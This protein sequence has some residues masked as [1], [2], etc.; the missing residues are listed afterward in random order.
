MSK[1][2]FSRRALMAAAAFG[3]TFGVLA[4][5]ASAEM[6]KVRFTMDWAW[7]GP[8]ATALLAKKLGYFEAEGVDI[9][10]NR[11]FGSGRVPV[12]L[13]AG[14]YDMGQGDMS[15]VI[16]FKA[17]NPDSQVMTVA[18]LYDGSPLVAVVKADGPI[19]SPKDFEGKTLAAPDFDAGRQLFPVFA[20]ATGIDM[21]KVNWMSVKPELREPM[22]AQGQADGITGFITS[23]KF[24][25]RALGME[26]GRD[27]T[28]FRYVDYGVDLYSTGIHTTRGFAEANP[29]AVTGTIRAMIKGTQAAMADID[30]AMAALKEHEPL[31]DVALE[32]DRLQTSFDELILT[33][34]VK[35]NGIS[36]VDPVR[37]QR[38]IASVEAAY[39]LP[40][41]VKVEDVYS[42]AYL[43]PR[44]DLMMN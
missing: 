34:T 41:K 39:G 37:M 38:N 29:K 13:A 35:A 27:V 12:D 36:F 8:Q 19:K 33:E 24:G 40:A 15:A 21:S 32:K 7:Q 11:G 31:T 25:L 14:T 5:P 18:V 3:A 23:S 17:E 42:D 43:P 26:E 44:E 2:Q 28:I 6:T 9:E 1:T 20:A 10:L 4:Q 30:A 22:L 16:K